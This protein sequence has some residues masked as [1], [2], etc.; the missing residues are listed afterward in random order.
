MDPTLPPR[1]LHDLMNHL[2]TVVGY[3]ELLIAQFPPGDPRL[4]DVQEIHRAANEAIELCKRAPSQHN[5][6][7]P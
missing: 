3:S 6:L 4:M 5:S 1:F 7:E 2:A